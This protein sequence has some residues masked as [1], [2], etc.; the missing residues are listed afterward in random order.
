MDR[1][2]KIFQALSE[3]ENP[4]W[5]MESQVK[6]RAQVKKTKWRKEILLIEEESTSEEE[7]KVKKRAQVKKLDM[8]DSVQTKWR[9][10][11]K[12]KKA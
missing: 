6:K 5:R 8:K 2:I 11:S 12:G 3:E 10:G 1:R 7:S 9:I 4:K